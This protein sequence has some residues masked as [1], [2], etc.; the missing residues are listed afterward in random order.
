MS[1]SLIR[2]PP[3]TLVDRGTRLSF[4][5]LLVGFARD[6]RAQACP[7][8]IGSTGA[9]AGSVAGCQCW[10]VLKGYIALADVA[11][12]F[13]E[14][15]V[16]FRSGEAGR[17]DRIGD[18]GASG[19]VNPEALTD[20]RCAGRPLAGSLWQGLGRVCTFLRCRNLFGE[21]G[22][23]VRV[24]SAQLGAEMSANVCPGFSAHDHVLRLGEERPG[25][26]DERERRF[27]RL[28]AA[29]VEGWSLD[30]RHTG[31]DGCEPAFGCGKDHLKDDHDPGRLVIEIGRGELEDLGG[32]AG[33]LL[34][35]WPWAEGCGEGVYC[36]GD[37][38]LKLV[39]GFVFL[40]RI[41]A[42]AAV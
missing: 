10:S 20:S 33:E 2:P 16:A 14:I 37:G 27:V 17:G 38:R 1:D 5:C 13:L 31:L 29:D 11:E 36:D 18:R 25:G 23:K 35:V 24:E 39:K 6:Q 12:A 30:A 3:D 22:G 42:G 4:R 19:G 7:D 41:R 32:K 9:R 26:V 8:T 15:V 40:C 28:F 21:V 34:D